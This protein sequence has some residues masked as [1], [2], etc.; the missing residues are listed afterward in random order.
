MNLLITWFSLQVILV[1]TKTIRIRKRSLSSRL[2]VNFLQTT[3]HQP[4]IELGLP[5][6]NRDT[7]LP[8]SLISTLFQKVFKRSYQTLNFNILIPNINSYQYISI[9]TTLS[10]LL[11]IK[12]RIP[13]GRDVLSQEKRQ[14]NTKSFL[15]RYFY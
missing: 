1:R 13:K 6:I 10:L 9:L 5:L 8:S 15:Q 7:T 3:I 12:D 2:S 11:Y 4:N 14:M